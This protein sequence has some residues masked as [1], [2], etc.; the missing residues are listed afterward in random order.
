MGRKILA[1]VGSV[2]GIGLFFKFPDL[3]ITLLGLGAHRYFLFHSCCLVAVLF[4]AGG[5]AGPR[6]PLAIFFRSLVAGCGIGIGIHLFADAFQA[7][8]VKFPFLGSLVDGTSLD[9]RLW[10]GLN[11]RASF[12]L[13]FRTYQKMKQALPRA[14]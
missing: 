4:Y 14:E 8:P 10:L 2:I 11:A 6:V 5:K 12:L 3:D 9:D 1:I 7:H 13:G